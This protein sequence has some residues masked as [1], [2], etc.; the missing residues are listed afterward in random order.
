MPKH[1]HGLGSVYQR[2]KTWWI[3]YHVNG[4]QFWESARTKDKAEAKKL[5]QAKIG[6]RAEG[7][8]VIGTH[9]VTFAS[10]LDLVERE[11]QENNRKTI[12]QI[13]QHRKHLAKCFAGKRA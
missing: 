6:Q 8:L 4:K 9:K 11:Y 5:L 7:T 13:R 2:G 10:L 1:K 3:T 12:K